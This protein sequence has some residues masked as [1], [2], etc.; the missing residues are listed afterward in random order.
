MNAPHMTDSEHAAF[1][2]G[3]NLA[4]PPGGEGLDAIKRAREFGPA[5]SEAHVAVSIPTA[6]KFLTVLDSLPEDLAGAA[7]LGFFRGMVAKSGGALVYVHHGGR[8]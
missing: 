3:F 7:W 6:K 2:R 1:M 8:A 5:R 4:Q